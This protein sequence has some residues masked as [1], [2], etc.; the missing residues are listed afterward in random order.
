MASAPSRDTASSRSGNAPPSAS[1][2]T[3]PSALPA[4]GLAGV[5]VEGCRSKDRPVVLLH[6]TFSTLASNF[7]ALVPALRAD[8][9][10]VYGIDYGNGGVDSIESSAAEIA[11]F[12]ETVSADTAATTIDVI[13]YSQG[14]LVLRTALRRDG[15][16]DRVSTAVLLAPSWNGTTSPL[17]GALPASICP[18]CADQI[19]GSA[20]LK[21][22]DRGGDLDGAVRYAE[23]STTGD[24]VVTPIASQIPAGPADRVRSIVV[25]RQCPNLRT[26]HVHLPAVRGVINWTLAALATG[27]RPPARALTC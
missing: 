3:V 7:S 15:L 18:A 27:G 16:A 14:G 4:A 23:V 10:C 5:N 19:A 26:D 17:A 6:G 25:E 21:E 11:A 13:A 2:H 24:T 1:G 20:L 12:V 9:R 8:G 22:L